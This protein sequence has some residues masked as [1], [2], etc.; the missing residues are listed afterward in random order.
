MKPVALPEYRHFNKYMVCGPE[1]GMRPG[2]YVPVMPVNY[3]LTAAGVGDYVNYSGALLWIAKTQPWLHG[4]V[5]CLDIMVPFLRH[6]LSPYEGW[7]VESGEHGNTLS[8]DVVLV[9]P[10]MEIN[11]ANVCPQLLG[12][13]HTH[14]FDLGFAFFANRCGAPPEA[15]LPYVTQGR[16]KLPKKLR[17]LAG[18]YVVFTPGVVTPSRETTGRHWNPVINHVT[19]RGMTPVFLGRNRIT[20]SLHADFPDDI[21]YDS[22]IDL[23]NQ[24]TLLDAAVICE[25]AN[26][27]IGLDN[28]LL[29]LAATTD[30]KIVFGYNIAAPEH[31]EPRRDWGRTVNVALTKGELACAHCQSTMFGTHLHSFHNCMYWKTTER[32]QRLDCIEMLFADEGQRWKDAIDAMSL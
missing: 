20:S 18:K 4:K 12:P 10:H 13:V 2:T 30:A 19:E 28:G 23:R 1:H 16:E 26:C 25:Y 22:G 14:L 15:K 7:S 29:H 8:S 21:A 6:V 31:R 24:T 3:V 32:G 11:G 27:V 9:A 5:Y 17:D